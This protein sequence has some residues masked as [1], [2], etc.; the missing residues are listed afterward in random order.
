MLHKLRVALPVTLLALAAVSSIDSASAFS[1]FGWPAV[2][3]Y[4]IPL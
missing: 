4:Y 2:A 1:W 3:G